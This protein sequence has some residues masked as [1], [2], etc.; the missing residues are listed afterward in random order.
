MLYTMRLRDEIG[1]AYFTELVLRVKEEKPLVGQEGEAYTEQ[2]ANF[3]KGLVED[4]IGYSLKG[5]DP[6]AT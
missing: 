5:Y 4:L 1:R 6:W 2:R 3:Y